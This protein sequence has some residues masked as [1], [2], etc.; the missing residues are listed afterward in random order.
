MRSATR[1]LRP[2][3]AAVAP[4]RPRAAQS[5]ELKHRRGP[6]RRES[7]GRGRGRG[8][9]R[10]AAGDGAVGEAEAEGRS[11]YRPST[12]Q[13]M[14]EDASAALRRALDIAEREGER[15]GQGAGVA[16]GRL[17]EIQMPSLPGGLE[18]E[19]RGSSDDFQ[20]A[21]IRLAMAAAKRLDRERYKDVAIVMPDEGEKKFYGRQ[22]QTALEY[23]PGLRFEALTDVNG[24]G[25][26]GGLLNSVFGG[27]DQA[28]ASK[29]RKADIYFF[30]NAS[31]VELPTLERFI[32]EVVGGG[33][34]AVAFNLELDTLRSDLGLFGF[35][36]KA[37]HYTFLSQFLP[38]YYIRQRDYSKTIAEPPFVC[39]YRCVRRTPRVCAAP[40]HPARVLTHASPP[41]M[42]WD[43]LPR[44]PGAVAGDAQAVRRELRVRRGGLEPLHALRREGGARERRGAEHGGRGLHH[45][46]PAPRVQARHL[47][48][49]GARR[50][51]EQPV[52]QLSVCARARVNQSGPFLQITRRRPRSRRLLSSASAS[53]TF[54]RRRR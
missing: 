40:P 36:P 28:S 15:E 7:A 10:A 37:L 14:V 2:G 51:D 9:G 27:G 43:A 19:Q 38:V 39:N 4:R 41:P 34:P 20:A 35:P 29:R 54:G 48:G 46:L 50:R 33:T 30:V 8:Y 44:V 45:G 25:L 42:Q 17:L 23:I 6:P 16:S 22:M 11:L 24:D 21:N 49:G 53:V 32:D 26:I 52:A 47:V 1:G 3:M 31:T 12:Y 13:D 5:R 18:M